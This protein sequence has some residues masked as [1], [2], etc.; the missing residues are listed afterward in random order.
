MLFSFAA[1]SVVTLPS[2]VYSYDLISINVTCTGSLCCRNMYIISYYT[3]YSLKWTEHI[4]MSD[5]QVA[6]QMFEWEP[7][8]RSWGQG[9]PWS[10]RVREFSKTISQAGKVTEYNIGSGKV[11]ENDFKVMEFFITIVQIINHTVMIQY[12]LNCQQLRT[13]GN[14]FQQAATADN[15]LSPTVA[16]SVLI[17]YGFAWSVVTEK[18]WKISVEK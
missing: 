14:D 10:W 11:I 12:A 15:Y 16:S 2:W 7:Y 1:S 17:G 9:V 13:A 5:N 18:S 6:K 4:R 8:G 3:V